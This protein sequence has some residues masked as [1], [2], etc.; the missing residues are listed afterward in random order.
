LRRAGLPA[1]AEREAE[2]QLATDR[3]DPELQ[4]EH[5]ASSTI[6]SLREAGMA[7][8]PSPIPEGFPS[9]RPYL[10]I[11]GAAQAIEFYERAFGGKERLRLAIPG[12]R[13]A[14]AELEIGHAIVAL[15]DPLP[16]F[17][18]RP[19][20]Q[21]GGTSAEVLIYVEDVDG[22]VERAV[23][24]GATIRQEPADQPWGDRLGGITDPFGHMWLIATRIEDLT[25]EEITERL[26]AGPPQG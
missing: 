7:E 20:T 17:E 23:A 21:L 26:A 25:P 22:T 3:L 12:G 8:A 18:P 14:H 10:H 2:H 9:V 13:I 4:A 15:C 1:D 11:D 16:Q 6:I 19:P 5:E 24:A